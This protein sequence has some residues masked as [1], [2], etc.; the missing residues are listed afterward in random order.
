MEDSLGA[1]PRGA[2]TETARRR[3]WFGAWFSVPTLA[4]AIAA[5]VGRG[6]TAANSGDTVGTAGG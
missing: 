1:G 2:L 4:L 6:A 5:M 3:T